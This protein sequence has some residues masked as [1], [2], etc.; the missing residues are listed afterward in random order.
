M[1]PQTDPQTDSSS[2]VVYE[3]ALNVYRDVRKEYK[4]LGR[5]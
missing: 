3:L 4:E 5:K 1:I 2:P